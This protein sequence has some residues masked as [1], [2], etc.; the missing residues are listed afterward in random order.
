[1]AFTFVAVTN[2]PVT[3][4]QTLT[5]STD[6]SS[7]A[8]SF[9]LGFKPRRITVYQKTTPAEYGWF[10]GM[11]AAHMKKTIAAG[12]MTQETSNGITVAATTALTGGP[13]VVTLGTGLHTNSAAYHIVCER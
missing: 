8:G 11:T 5:A 1:M 7:A 12:T 10:E 9:T 4:L 13:W 2:D 6:T 3:G